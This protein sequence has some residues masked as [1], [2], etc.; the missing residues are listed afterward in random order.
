MKPIDETFSI[1]RAKQRIDSQFQSFRWET[2]GLDK[3]ALELD[4]IKKNLTVYYKI[5]NRR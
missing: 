1:Q 3:C 2:C 4:D 5:K